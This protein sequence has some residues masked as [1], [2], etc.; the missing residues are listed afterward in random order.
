M[1]TCVNQHY[2]YRGT[3]TSWALI[4]WVVTYLVGVLPIRK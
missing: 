2:I 4:T 1:K 3:A